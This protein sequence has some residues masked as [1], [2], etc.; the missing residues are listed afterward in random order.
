MQAFYNWGPCDV[1]SDHQT[2]NYTCLE[3]HCGLSSL[4]LA[5]NGGSGVCWRREALDSIGGFKTESLGEP[6]DLV[7]GRT[8]M[9]WGGRKGCC[10]M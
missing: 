7:R 10:T 5:P 8:G 2:E 4:G 6:R 9:K 1:M 3:S